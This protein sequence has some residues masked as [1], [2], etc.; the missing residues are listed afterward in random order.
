MRMFLIAIFSIFAMSSTPGSAQVKG[1]V[2]LVR[3]LV[4]PDVYNGKVVSVSGVLHRADSGVLALY[5]D[6]SSAESGVT[7]NAIV[8]LLAGQED[9]LT[10]QEIQM[11]IG[12]YVLVAATFDTDPPQTRG[13]SGILKAIEALRPYP[14][15]QPLNN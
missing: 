14:L 2:P 12:K 11:A 3:L 9:G 7:A 13:Y 5:L 6:P 8:L 1:N 10:E 15:L 4:T